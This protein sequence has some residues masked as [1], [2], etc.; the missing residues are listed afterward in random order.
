MLSNPGK[1]V[2]IYN[3]AGII[4]K[5][6]GKAF[7]KCNIEKGFN[8]AGIHP[9][10]EN[11][12]DEDE[13][14]SS[15]VTDRPYSQ[16]SESDNAPSRSLGSKHNTAVISKLRTSTKI[17]R[18][19]KEGL[20]PEIIRPFPK[21]G[22]RKTGGRKHEKTRILRDTPEKNKTENQKCKKGKVKHSRKTLVKMRLITVD[23][24]EEDPEDV[25]YAEFSDDDYTALF[26]V[27][28]LMS[29]KKK[30]IRV[31][32]LEMWHKEILF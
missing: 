17:I 21:A 12:F 7:T 32:Y 10:N 6:F 22:P 19:M 24:S 29:L 25:A 11:I 14:L 16:V 4:G 9:L 8:V 2:T 18:R 5:A 13:F 26:E 1:P 30:W 27:K 20:S 31:S 28:W 3:A 23:S 15:Y